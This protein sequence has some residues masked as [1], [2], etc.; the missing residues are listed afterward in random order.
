MHD[1]INLDADTIFSS[2]PTAINA[3]T[4]NNAMNVSLPTMTSNA[5]TSPPLLPQRTTTLVCDNP[6]DSSHYVSQ[7]GVR[8]GS[9]A[10]VNNNQ[11]APPSVSSSSANNPNNPKSE[12]FDPYQIDS[13]FNNVSPPMTQPP[14]PSTPTY[15]PTPAQHFTPTS[16]IATTATAILPPLP[17]Y[18]QQKQHLISISSTATNTMNQPPLPVRPSSPPIYTP[19]NILNSASNSSHDS[20]HFHQSTPSLPIYSPPIGNTAQHTTSHNAHTYNNHTA[21][22]LPGHASLPPSYSNPLPPHPQSTPTATSINSSV[23]PR[24]ALP[25]YSSAPPTYPTSFSTSTT[26]I[27]SHLA[28]V[29]PLSSPKLQPPLPPYSTPPPIYSANPTLPSYTSPMRPTTALPPYSTDLANSQKQQP[30]MIASPTHTIA[31]PTMPQPVPPSPSAAIFGSSSSSTS[32]LISSIPMTPTVKRQSS[33]FTFDENEDE[34]FGSGSNSSNLAYGNRGLFRANSPPRSKS[35]NGPSTNASN[36]FNAN[37]STHL[38]NSNN[39]NANPS[40]NPSISQASSILVPQASYA[41]SNFEKALPSVSSL[42]SSQPINIP[43]ATTTTPVTAILLPNG[44]TT[45]NQSIEHAPLYPSL[46]QHVASMPSHSS[47]GMSASSSLDRRDAIPEK[48]HSVNS[49]TINNNN[50]GT[51]SSGANSRRNTTEIMDED[52]DG[53]YFFGS[54][55]KTF[56]GSVCD[57]S[58]FSRGVSLFSFLF[59]LFCDSNFSN[60]VEGEAKIRPCA[61]RF[62]ERGQHEDYSQGG[63]QRWSEFAH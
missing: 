49:N 34:I 19:Q 4:S 60:S 32:H 44:T 12:N 43:T 1:A 42:P 5:T 30:T 57:A 8:K 25:I 14:M 36:N 51:T 62:A 35:P 9:F 38:P 59:C 28:T 53:D 58:I 3:T 10:P 13:I 29:V 46:H 23:S 56:W 20:L 27:P 55:P 6:Y 16:P 54:I 15:T 37:D 52:G 33:E 47:S 11:S 63:L 21:P 17:P 61:A 7:A 48:T 26:T 50:S 40:Q 24:P 2:P 41:V 22:I 18:E 31:H 45:S 39:A